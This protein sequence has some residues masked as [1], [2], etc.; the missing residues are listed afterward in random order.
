MHILCVH[1]A[2]SSEAIL[3]R[4]TFFKT[5]PGRVGVPVLASF[6]VFL[7]NVLILKKLSNIPLGKISKIYD[8]CYYEAATYI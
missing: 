2:L 8:L 1:A 6:L 7:M 4:L 3:C 5:S